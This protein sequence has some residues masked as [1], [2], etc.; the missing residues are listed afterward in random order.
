MPPARTGGPQVH[1]PVAQGLQFAL[2]W[3]FQRPSLGRSAAGRV[4]LKPAASFFGLTELASLRGLAVDPIL[5]SPGV[6]D[7]KP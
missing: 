1:A 5:D 4:F 7:D 6:L 3:G 2:G